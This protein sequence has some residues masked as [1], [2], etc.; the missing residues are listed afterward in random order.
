M[1]AIV[2]GCGEPV[3]SGVVV[4]DAR[5]RA[6]IA[7]RDSTVAYLTLTN[8]GPGPVELVGVAS[9]DGA[10]VALHT[11]VHEGDTMRMRPLPRLALPPDVAVR[12][13]PGGHHLM[14]TGVTAVPQSMVLLLQYADGTEQAVTF[15]RFELGNDR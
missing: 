9:P 12:F 5:I 3:A 13:E 6:P 8:H 15:Q 11:H 1:L 14:V 4:T 2:G 7:G 10:G